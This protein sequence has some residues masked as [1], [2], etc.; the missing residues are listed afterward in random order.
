MYMSEVTTGL[1]ICIAFSL[2]LAEKEQVHGELY[3]KI[4]LGS[5]PRE[6]KLEELS[7]ERKRENVYGV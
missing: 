2:V 5:K 3:I 7:R 6:R 1:I 4:T